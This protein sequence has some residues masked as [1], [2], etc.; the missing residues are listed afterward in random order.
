[1]PARMIINSE[2]MIG[3]NSKLKQAIA[4]TILVVNIEVNPE[5]KKAALKLMAGG[6]SK[7]NLLNSHP[8]NS[9]HTTASLQ[10]NKASQP[11]I[12]MRLNTK[13][14]ATSSA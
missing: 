14:S 6:P 10:Q 2:S 12:M 5:T 8:S 1:M 7:I 11:T 3:F 4:G 9:I 13:E